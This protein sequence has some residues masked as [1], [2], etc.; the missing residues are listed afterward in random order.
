MNKLRS[1]LCFTLT[2]ALILFC[3]SA[4]AKE[5]TETT[6]P[7]TDPPLT[8]P[9]GDPIPVYSDVS[10]SKLDP[11]LFTLLDNG[12]YVY[13]DSSV[14]TSAGIDVSTFQ[15]DV[16]WAA[17]KADGID[18]VMLRVGYRGYG[19][20][21]KL[22][23]DER[24]QANYAAAAAAGLKIGVYFFSQ[25]V[26]PAEAK[27]EAEFVLQRI[28]GLK[29]DYPI[30][31]D[32]EAIDYDQARTDGMS[33]AEISAC[34]AAFCDRIAKERYDVLIYFNRELGYFNYDLSIV[35]DYHF[36]LAEY[37]E[38]PSFVYDYKMWQ[39]TRNGKVAG[40][41]GNVDLNICV[42]QYGGSADARAYTR[43]GE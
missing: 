19:A 28:K 43:K 33:S 18:F 11:S 24:F 41:E 8:S 9:N 17:V 20:E 13:A 12:R 10:L 5:E 27:E 31:Y 1:L 26:T 25:A 2:F 16:D 35:K 36:W 22:G 32:W 40:I 15:G 38:K 14:H 6:A 37:L 30:A 21:G 39:Y 29:L 42:Y 4:C 3:V 23:E 7:V 34:A